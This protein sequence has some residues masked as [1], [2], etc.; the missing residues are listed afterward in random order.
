MANSKPLPTPMEINEKLTSSGNEKKVDSTAY[1]QL[2]G[3][4]IYATIRVDVLLY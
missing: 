4:L 1:R 2:V 3:S